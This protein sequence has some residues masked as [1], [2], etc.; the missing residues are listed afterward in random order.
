MT[1]SPASIVKVVDE[2]IG[3]VNLSIGLMGRICGEME[4]EFQVSNNHSFTATDGT[5]PKRSL[6]RTWTPPPEAA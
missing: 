3:R 5:M 6:I 4:I 1:G 2:D